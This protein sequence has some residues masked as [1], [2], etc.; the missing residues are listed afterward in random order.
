MCGR[1]GYGGGGLEAVYACR[2]SRNEGSFMVRSRSIVVS[3]RPKRSLMVFQ[4]L[5]VISEWLSWLRAF[6][7]A[8]RY[9]FSISLRLSWVLGVGGW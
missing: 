9:M 1:V 8:T 5:D 4:R 3:S 7:L 6:S 2:L